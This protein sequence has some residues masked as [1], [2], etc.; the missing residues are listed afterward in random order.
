MAS[1]SSA[2]QL[3]VHLA[4]S[5]TCLV[6]APWGG[7]LIWQMVS[8]LVQVCPHSF[9]SVLIYSRSSF[10]PQLFRL[11]IQSNV[12]L[13]VCSLSVRLVGVEPNLYQSGR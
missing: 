8:G 1:N 7:G 9:A 4:S 12:P 13:A 2:V 5:P 3:L 6:M 11:L 10:F